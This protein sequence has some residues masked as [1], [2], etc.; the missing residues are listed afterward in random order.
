MATISRITQIF[1]DLDLL[2]SAHPNT[3][4]VVKKRDEDAIKQSVKN[5]ILTQYY[6]R[7]FH[8]EIGSPVRGLLFELAT[9]LTVHTLK[10]GIIDTLTNFE[11]RIRV[12]EVNVFMQDETNS[13]DIVITYEIIGLQTT[14]ELTITVER[15]R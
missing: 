5:L 7:P 15:T 6:E 3:K 14:E 1:K 4:D 11:P 13:C 10:R 9:P 2:F 8:S 12:L